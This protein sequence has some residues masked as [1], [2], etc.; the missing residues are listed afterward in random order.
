MS[1]IHSHFQLLIVNDLHSIEKEG[2]S[3]F[4]SKSLFLYRLSQFKKT[5][6]IYYYISF[7]LR[8]SLL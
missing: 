6:K 8:N 2:L 1:A 4:S 3:I 5:F 7:F